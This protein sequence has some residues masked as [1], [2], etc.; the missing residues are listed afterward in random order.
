MKTIDKIDRGQCTKGSGQYTMQC[1]E[2]KQK[3]KPPA[4]EMIPM[5]P[6]TSTGIQ[7]RKL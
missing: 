7:T 1:G 5:T 6:T 2:R 3:Q 4:T